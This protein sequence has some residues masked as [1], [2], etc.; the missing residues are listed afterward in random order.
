MPKKSGQT[1]SLPSSAGHDCE[2]PLGMMTG[3][4]F[5]AKNG[6]RGSASTTPTKSYRRRMR[7]EFERLDPQSDRRNQRP[8]RPRRPRE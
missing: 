6:V 8:D 2:D 7:A 1:S 5:D 3:T 4:D